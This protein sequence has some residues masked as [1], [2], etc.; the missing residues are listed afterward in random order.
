[1]LV[2]RQPRHLGA[3]APRTSG[4]DASAEREAE[5]V[6]R[7]HG[8]ARR[9]DVEHL[10]ARNSC[11]RSRRAQHEAVAGGEGQRRRQHESSE[12]ALVVEDS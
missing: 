12:L 5:T 3:C 6:D 2:A 9:S 7:I 1:M 4:E 10:G 11:L 8:S